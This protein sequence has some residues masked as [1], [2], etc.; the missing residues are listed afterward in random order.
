MEYTKRLS[1]LSGEPGYLQAGL[2]LAG[3]IFLFATAAAIY[4]FMEI[5]CLS[6]TVT[7]NLCQRFLMRMVTFHIN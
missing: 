6:A 2:I 1:R 7:A 4:S 3:V 5:P